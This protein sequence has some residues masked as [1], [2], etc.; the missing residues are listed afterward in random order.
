MRYDGPIIDA[1]HHLWDL[2]MGRHPWLIEG[3]PAM[4]SLGDLGFLRRDYLIADY[5]ADIGAQNVVGSVCV[6][7]VWDRGR[8][9]EEEAAWIKA[10]DRPRAIA[11]RVVAW[12][13]L[14][15][16]EVEGA[17]DVLEA[18]GNVAGV[19]ETIRWHPDPAK[20][21]TE[22]GILDRPEWRQGAAALARRGLVLDV[23]MNPYQADD[24]ARLARDIPALRIVVNHCGTPV[25]RDDAGLAR[26]RAGLRAMAEH[27][28]VA[29]KLS[30]YGAYG[31]DRSLPALRA[32]LM[33]CIDAFG[34]A[35]AMFGSDYPVGRRAMSYAEACERFK[36]VAEGFSG[37]EQRALFCA[38]AASIYGFEAA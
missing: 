3:D 33:T 26:W 9:V 10:L 34:V 13:P 24:V 22:A 5:L 31:A 14:A 20:R 18:Q 6:E 37:G 32:V 21:W 4:Q 15:S 2:S 25:D 38:N 19:R 12:A 17:L 29:I 11:S 16:P 36:D 35:R 1:H 27:P 28:N 23:L 7:A 8:P 30:N